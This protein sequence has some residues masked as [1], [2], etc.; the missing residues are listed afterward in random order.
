MEWDFN[1]AAGFTEQDDGLAESFYA[2]ALAPGDI[3]ARR[4]SS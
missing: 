4:R 2:D 1:K 3:S